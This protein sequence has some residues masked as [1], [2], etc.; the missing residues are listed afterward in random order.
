MFIYP[1]INEKATANPAEAILFPLTCACPV[2]FGA[3]FI[4]PFAPSVI[5][6]VPELVPELVSKTRS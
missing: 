3:M 2:P 4:L 5:V 6:I 1:K